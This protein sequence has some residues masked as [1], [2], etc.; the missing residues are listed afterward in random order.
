VYVIVDGASFADRSQFPQ[1]VAKRLKV[2]DFIESRMHSP[3]F[4]KGYAPGVADELLKRVADARA[5]YLALEQT[6]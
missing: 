5:K 6:P 3:R 1:L 2:L 4:T